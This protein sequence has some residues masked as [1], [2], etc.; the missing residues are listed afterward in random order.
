[1]S[2]NACSWV[3]VWQLFVIAA[4]AWIFGCA[5]YLTLLAGALIEMRFGIGCFI[6]TDQNQ[7]KKPSVA[8]GLVIYAGMRIMDSLFSTKP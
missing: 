5:L 4:V 3:V 2:I 8:G 7:Q 6:E 1:M